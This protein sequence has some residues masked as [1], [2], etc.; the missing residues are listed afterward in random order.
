[1]SAFA[2]LVSLHHIY[3][4]RSQLVDMVVVDTFLVVLL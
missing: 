3:T 4:V 2:I 1:M